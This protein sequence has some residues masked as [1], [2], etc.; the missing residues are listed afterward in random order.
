V[1]STVTTI[2]EAPGDTKVIEAELV[3]INPARI[4]EIWPHVRQLLEK[5]CRRTGLNAFADFEAD[6]LAG[7]S[8]VWVAWNGHAIEAAAATVLI[9][10]DFGKVCVITLCAGRKMSRWVKLIDRIEAYA[11]DEGCARIRI[12]G[13]K[14]WLRVLET[15][16]LR[17]VVMDKA[18]RK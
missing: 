4:H 8:L 14:G 15:Y 7:R 9:N 12:F 2:A 11:R 5:A 17:H 1:P 10:S 6:I 3:C 13:R 18:L 16:E